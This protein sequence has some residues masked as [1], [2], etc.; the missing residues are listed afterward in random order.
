M[1]TISLAELVDQGA[2]LKRFDHKYVLPAGALPALI[3]ALPPDTRIL[4]IDGRRLFPYRSTYFDTPGLD[5]YL[6]AAHRR[7]RRA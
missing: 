4:A 7:Q 1:R 2:L 6:G 5:S 3:G